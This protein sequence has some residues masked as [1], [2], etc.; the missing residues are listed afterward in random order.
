[1]WNTYF[2]WKNSTKFTPYFAVGVGA[3]RI[4]IKGTL[5]WNEDWTE[6]GYGSGTWQ[7]NIAKTSKQ[8]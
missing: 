2:D 4:H 5:S 1:M 7:Q 8:T 6:V 3:T